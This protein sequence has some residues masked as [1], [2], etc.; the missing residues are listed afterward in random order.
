MDIRS[1]VEMTG[2]FHIH[3][4]PENFAVIV[5]NVVT[6]E[7]VDY[8]SVRWGDERLRSAYKGFLTLSSI[9]HRLTLTRGMHAYVFSS[10][11]SSSGSKWFWEDLGVGYQDMFVSVGNFMH[12][13][14]RTRH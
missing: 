12:T 10:F 4:N 5:D 13:A 7:F 6:S 2:M 3:A 1:G 9:T 14:F 8:R 11:V